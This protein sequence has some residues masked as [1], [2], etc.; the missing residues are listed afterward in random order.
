MRLCSKCSI[1]LCRPSAR[2]YADNPVNLHFL[3]GK[4]LTGGTGDGYDGSETSRSISTA[5]SR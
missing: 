1:P 5:H 4:N 2:V 3:H